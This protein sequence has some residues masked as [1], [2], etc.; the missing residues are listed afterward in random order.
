MG[1]GVGTPC[2]TLPPP[3]LRLLLSLI[4]IRFRAYRPPDGYVC[5]VFT[6]V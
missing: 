3:H 1:A 5:S 4:C 2:P 6:F